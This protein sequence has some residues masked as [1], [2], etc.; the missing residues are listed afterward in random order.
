MSQRSVTDEVIL[1][2]MK[3]VASLLNSRPITC[4]S[5]NSAEP[6]P[7]T[8]NHFIMGCHHPLIPPYLETEFRFQLIRSIPV[9]SVGWDSGIPHQTTE[10]FGNVGSRRRYGRGEESNQ[11]RRKN[12]VEKKL[13]RS[14][15]VK[16]KHKLV[17]FGLGFRCENNKIRI[18]IN[19]RRYCF[20]KYKFLFGPSWSRFLRRMQII[21]YSLPDLLLLIQ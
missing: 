3:E 4:V 15:K 5:T 13:P 17:I 16:C 20:H 21:A 10:S 11:C 6:E 9:Y 12:D 7:L 18:V 8:P 19:I 2:V 14:E 1:I